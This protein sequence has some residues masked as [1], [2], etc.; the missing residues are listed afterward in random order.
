MSGERRTPPA[1]QAHTIALHAAPGHR[2]CVMTAIRRSQVVIVDDKAG[3]RDAARELLEARGYE[4]VAEATDANMAREAVARHDPTGVLLD[5]R[6]GDDDGFAVCRELTR[7]HPRLAVLLVSEADY[8]Q[9]PDFIG[10][11]ARGFVRKSRL[12]QVDLGQFWASA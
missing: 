3:F 9:S 8:G 1:G 7:L 5:I 2:T 4:V 10:C 11:G 6:L 12:A